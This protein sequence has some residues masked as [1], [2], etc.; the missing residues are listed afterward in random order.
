[1]SPGVQAHIFMTAASRQVHLPQFP[2]HMF[3]SWSRFS[4][5]PDALSP[6]ITTPIKNERPVIP[7]ITRSVVQ[8]CIK[9]LEWVFHCYWVLIVF[10]LHI[11]A[12]KWKLPQHREGSVISSE[13][14]RAWQR[15]LWC[16]FHATPKGKIDYW[17]Q[18]ASVFIF[19]KRNRVRV[20]YSTV[21]KFGARFFIFI[22]KKVS[23]AHYG[24]IYLM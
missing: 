17:P 13:L 21:Q 18:K 10:K 5:Y 22:W 3:L 20:I 4:S 9:A 8:L 11:A 14:R 24:C 23:Y 15:R 6:P 1:M 12:C 19:Y 2:H 16:Y 7:L